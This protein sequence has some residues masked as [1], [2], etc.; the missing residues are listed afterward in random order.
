MAFNTPTTFRFQ[1]VPFVRKKDK[2]SYGKHGVKYRFTPPAAHASVRTRILCAH[3]CSV[4]RAYTV[5]RFTQLHTITLNGSPGKPVPLKSAMEAFTAHAGNSDEGR[6]TPGVT[7]T[8]QGNTNCYAYVKHM[9]RHMVLLS[10]SVKRGEA[11]RTAEA[12]AAADEIFM[13]MPNYDRDIAR[14]AGDLL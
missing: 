6:R 4:R 3:W 7:W 13:S 10:H 8:E 14:V 9:M 12:E 2:G 5:C 1:R 11:A